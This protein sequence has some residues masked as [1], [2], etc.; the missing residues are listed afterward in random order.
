MR[1]CRGFRFLG[2]TKVLG[3]LVLG[4]VRVVKDGADRGVRVSAICRA[5]EVL[6][7]AYESVIKFGGPSCGPALN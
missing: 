2:R 1:G 7:R 5:S 4:F 3:M 6:S